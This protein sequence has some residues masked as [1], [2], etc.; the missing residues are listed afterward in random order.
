MTTRVVWWHTRRCAALCFVGGS[1]SS[2]FLLARRPALVTPILTAASLA[3]SLLTATVF[4][5]ST[6]SRTPP[7]AP[8]AD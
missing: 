8:P 1:T 6:G 2:G 4:L 7:H 5:P 3:T